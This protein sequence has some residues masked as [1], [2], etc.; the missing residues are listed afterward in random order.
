M[1]KVKSK[2]DVI[3]NSSTEVFIMFNEVNEDF[4]K[5]MKDLGWKDDK[6][7]LWILDSLEKIRE[8]LR[9]AS[10]E[11][12]TRVISFDNPYRPGGLVDSLEEAGKTK[13]EIW[14]FLE[15]LFKNLVGKALYRVCMEGCYNWDP[16]EDVE[17]W[18]KNHP[19]NKLKMSVDRDYF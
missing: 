15:P 17:N 18:V 14:K 8:F 19:D 13:D 4:R 6:N 12:I 16:C 5:L 1:I 3:T 9:E 10:D 2:T 11:E 7:T